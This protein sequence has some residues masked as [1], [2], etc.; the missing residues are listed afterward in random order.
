MSNSLELRIDL[1]HKLLIIRDMPHIISIFCIFLNTVVFILLVPLSAHAQYLMAENLEEELM[2]RVSLQSCLHSVQC[3]PK[4]VG[5]KR[6][7]WQNQCTVKDYLLHGHG[8]QVQQLKQ[9]SLLTSSLESPFLMDPEAAVFKA[10]ILDCEDPASA[11]AI[12]KSS[13]FDLGKST[14]TPML[15][16]A[17]V[18]K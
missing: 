14:L 18:R 8:K 7:C 2:C 13:K 12:V 4:S 10:R 16:A 5:H 15:G 1:S 17:S 9:G 6:Y 3:T 11:R